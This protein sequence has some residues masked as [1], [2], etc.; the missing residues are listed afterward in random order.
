MKQSR[1]GD[2][3]IWDLFKSI[4]LEKEKYK[5]QIEER[6]KEHTETRW[7]SKLT[8]LGICIKSRESASY[9]YQEGNTQ[10]TD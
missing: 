10:E 7:D 3:L 5:K 1:R 2:S 6:T 4:E 8:S 9:L